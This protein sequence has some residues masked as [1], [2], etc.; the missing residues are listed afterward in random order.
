MVRIHPLLFPIP[1]LHGCTPLSAVASHQSSASASLSG[2][3]PSHPAI[4]VRLRLRSLSGGPTPLH[5]TPQH[6]TQPSAFASA[7]SPPLLHFCLSTA[8]PSP[9]SSE[10]ASRRPELASLPPPNPRSSADQTLDPPLRLRRGKQHGASEE[11]IEEVLLRFPPEEPASLFRAVLVCKPWR[12]L[13]CGR[14][15]R[16]RFREFHRSPPMLG[17]L[18]NLFVEDCDDDSRF[19]PI[20]RLPDA[21]N[22]V[23]DAVD[24]RHGL[25]LLESY[26]DDCDNYRILVWDPTTDECWKLPLS[27]HA[28]PEWLYKNEAVLCAATGSGACDHLNCH[29]RPFIVVSAVN[30]ATSE[31]SL[32]VYSS[33]AGAWSEPTLLLTDGDYFLDEVPTALV[34]NT[35]YFSTG[36]GSRALMYDLATH[37]TYFIGLPPPVDRRCAIALMTMKDDGLGVAQLDESGTLSLWSMEVNPNGDMGMAWTQI[38]VIELDKLLPAKAHSIWPAFVGFTRDVGVFF[39]WADDRLLFTFDLMS[40]GVRKVLEEPWRCYGFRC[41]FP[42]MSFY[43]PA[44]KDAE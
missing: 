2:A 27:P 43:T 26:D 35:L 17:F 13:I 40:G 22:R 7:P 23:G 11:L 24:A 32:C 28:D 12:R 10:V 18:S 8:S 37:E 3:P 31:L 16:R 6:P 41:V 36:K 5:S 42:Y 33:E 39:V 21:N 30:T 1:P 20:C 19:T 15:F 38:R 25:A 4:R 34:G 44:L 9:P 29:G 14:R